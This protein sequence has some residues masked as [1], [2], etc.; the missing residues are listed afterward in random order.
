MSIPAPLLELI[1]SLLL[2]A[3]LVVVAWVVRAIW[4]EF[5]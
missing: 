1:I 5:Q 3:W 2:A 4:R